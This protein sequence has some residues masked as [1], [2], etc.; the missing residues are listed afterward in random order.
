[1]HKQIEL[2][3]L[4]CSH[5][6]PLLYEWSYILFEKKEKTPL[7]QSIFFDWKRVCPFLCLHIF[8]QKPK[9]TSWA[10]INGILCD[11]EIENYLCFLFPFT[12]SCYEFESILH[13]I[14]PII[15]TNVVVRNGTVLFKSFCMFVVCFEIYYGMNE[16]CH[17]KILC[18]VGEI[19]RVAHAFFR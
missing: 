3:Y 6:V 2:I 18:Y 7:F 9:T 12:W 1:M 13:C 16:Y 10:C 17:S 11:V 15:E 19:R 5:L 14:A 8:F 4:L